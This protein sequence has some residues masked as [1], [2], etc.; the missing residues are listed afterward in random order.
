[1]GLTD[2]EGQRFWPLYREYRSE[3]VKNGDRTMAL[4]ST[5]A[6]NYDNLSEGTAEWMVNEFL[7]IEKVES[8]VKSRWVPRFPW[9]NSRAA[10]RW[11][12][13]S[14]NLAQMTATA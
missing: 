2:V 6:D 3:L 9:C 8:R 1:M 5:F 13:L 11:V 4:V 14:R 7:A 12:S 10:I